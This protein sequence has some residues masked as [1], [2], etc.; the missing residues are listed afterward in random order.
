MFH[1]DDPIHAT[2]V[3][4]ANGFLGVIWTGLTDITNGFFITGNA[5]L[6]GVQCLGAISIFA[7]GFANSFL[8]FYILKYAI[9][10]LLCWIKDNPEDSLKENSIIHGPDAQLVGLDFLYFGGSGF[11]EFDVEAVSE[12]NATQRIKDKFRAKNVR[13]MRIF[14]R[15]V[16][17][18]STH[19]GKHTS[20]NR[21]SGQF[22]VPP[23]PSS[24]TANNSQPNTPRGSNPM[25][26]R[27]S[28]QTIVV[29]SQAYFV[30]N[31]DN[32]EDDR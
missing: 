7:W 15:E 6:L 9:P 4:C 14:D 18:V 29:D 1:V 12:F 21:T 17:D 2:A 20:F 28:E 19:G 30:N 24:A 11:P 3:H 32:D 10:Y 23:T 25:P 5:H 31:P 8:Y 16:P 22:H 13:T 27:P 26:K